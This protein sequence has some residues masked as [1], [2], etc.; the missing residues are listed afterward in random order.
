[1]A[2][3][4]DKLSASERGL[5]ARK[6]AS[7]VG[8]DPRDILLTSSQTGMGLGDD[9]RQGGLARDLADLLR[10]PDPHRAQTGE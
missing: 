9:P 1:V 2:T 6:L 10:E 4:I 3:K 7:Q 5:L 8:V